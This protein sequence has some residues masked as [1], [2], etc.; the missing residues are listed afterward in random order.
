MFFYNFDILDNFIKNNFLTN[1]NSEQD[2]IKKL[3]DLYNNKK[4]NLLNI[5]T[6]MLDATNAVSNNK[7][8]K[9]YETIQS[10]RKSFENLEKI[11]ILADKL[12]KDLNL[13]VELYNKSLEN[14]YNEIKANLVEYNK[15]KDELFYKIL[16]FENQNSDII[17]T[18]IELSLNIDHKKNS[19]KTK[20][21]LVKS[22]STQNEIID[23]DKNPQDNNTLLISEKE[24]KAFLPFYYKDIKSIFENSNNRF[25]TMQDVVN[26]LYVLPLNKF[27][28]SSISRF[29]ESFNLI[30]NKEKG[31]ITQAFDLGLELIYRYELNPIIIAACRNLDELDIYLDCLEENELY[32][33]NCFEI[34]FE[35]APQIVKNK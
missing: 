30:R 28:N 1:L 14:N 35:L 24:Q 13:T 9:F 25:V 21:A 7:L 33:F 5:T 29:R 4:N 3:M 17:N 27:K 26:N 23:I 32:D 22:F 34:K 6:N 15:K 2:N 16:E 19:K 11:E 18:T 20:L 31:S 8:D 12:N 10:L